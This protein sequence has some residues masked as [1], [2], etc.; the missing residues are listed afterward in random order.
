[1][2]QLAELLRKRIEVIAD[3]ELRDRDPDAQ[4]EALKDVSEKLMA[5]HQELSSQLPWRLN[6]FLERCSYDK[7]LAFIEEG[8]EAAS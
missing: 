7:A 4:L 6:H 2:E 8:R 5:L 3:H 1:M